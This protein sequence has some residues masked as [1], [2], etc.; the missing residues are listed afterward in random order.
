MHI[1]I[2]KKIATSLHWRVKKSA[3]DET[4]KVMPGLGLTKGAGDHPMSAD[5]LT[6]L[7]L[8]IMEKAGVPKALL[9]NIASHSL[10]ATLLS[11]AGKRGMKS[12][13]RQTLGYHRIKGEESAMT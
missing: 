11:A 1:Y 4:T 13:Y 8:E 5:E 7:M 2:I 9:T 10:K 6:Q 3:D 12:Q